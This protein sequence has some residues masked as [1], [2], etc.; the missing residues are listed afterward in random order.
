MKKLEDYPNI[1]VGIA[2]QLKAIGI[3]N[4]HQLKLMGS[5]RVILRL[6]ENNHKIDIQTYFK[7]EACLR[8]MP[9]YELTKEERS[10]MRVFYK[11]MDR[12]IET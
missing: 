7:I 3:S 4:F 9:W 11:S 12:Y 5:K 1:G 2:A 10:R 6:H 8:N